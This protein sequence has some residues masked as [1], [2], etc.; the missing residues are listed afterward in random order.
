MTLILNSAEIKECV[1][2][3]VELI[4]IIED[5]FK[6]LSLVMLIMIKTSMPSILF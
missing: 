3:N 6:S 2:F 1:K 5:A 4:P